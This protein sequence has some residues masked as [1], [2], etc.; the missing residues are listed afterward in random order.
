MFFFYNLSSYQNKRVAIIGLWNENEQ[1]RQTRIDDRDRQVQTVGPNRQ[2][3]IRA[4]DQ[5]R[6][7][8]LRNISE[9]RKVVFKTVWELSNAR[10]DQL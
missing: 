4:N 2:I 7:K 8:M 6:G 1:N 9:G 5:G 10:F 3:K